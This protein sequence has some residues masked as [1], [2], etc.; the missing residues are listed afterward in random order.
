MAPVTVWLDPGLTT[1]WARFIAGR[2]DDDN[3]AF[4]SGETDF[5][6]LG[7]QLELLGDTWGPMLALG[8]ESFQITAGTARKKGSHHAIEVIGMVKWIAHKHKVTVL[9]SAPN[10]SRSLAGLQKLKKIGWYTPGLIHGNVAAE[11][12]LAF[13]MSQRLLPD[14]LMKKIVS[15]TGEVDGVS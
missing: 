3:G 14:V 15:Q 12:L 1:G 6:V 2:S 13:F 9:P 11:H 5:K 8:W 10:S 7:G 4:H